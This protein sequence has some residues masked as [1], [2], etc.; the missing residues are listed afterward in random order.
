MSWIPINS[1][2]Q[3]LTWTSQWKGSVVDEL[4]LVYDLKLAAIKCHSRRSISIPTYPTNNFNIF[5]IT[6]FLS[7]TYSIAWQ[8]FFSRH[9]LPLNPWLKHTR[10]ELERTIAFQKA[11]S[12]EQTIYTFTHERVCSIHL[13]IHLRIENNSAEEF[14]NATT[15]GK[16]IF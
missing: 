5:A 4:L 8:I 15:S 14:R 9:D 12:I 11:A 10:L 2:G 16:L 3:F 7:L 6:P 13:K 1:R